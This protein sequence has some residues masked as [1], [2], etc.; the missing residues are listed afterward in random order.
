[1]RKAGPALAGAVASM[2]GRLAAS[3]GVVSSS[4]SGLLAALVRE[5]GLETE[6]GCVEPVVAPARPEAPVPARGRGLTEATRAALRQLG[7]GEDASSSDVAAAYLALV[8]R[9]DPVRLAPL[10][11][12]FVAL[13]VREIGA[14]TEVYERAR[15]A[16]LT[17][18][19]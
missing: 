19:R 15:T 17:S 5:L 18:R 2:L 3:D 7:L 14:L 8:E 4:E 6:A 12:D 10:G 11:A 1:V 16:V 9:Y 13:A